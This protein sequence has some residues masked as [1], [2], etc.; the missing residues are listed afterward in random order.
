MGTGQPVVGSHAML[1]GPSWQR[2]ESHACCGGG[3]AG[4][5]GLGRQPGIR[6]LARRQSHPKQWEP[7]AGGCK[8]G[9]LGQPLCA[10]LVSLLTSPKLGT[11]APTAGL[12]VGTA[13]LLGQAFWN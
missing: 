1:V 11:Q 8:P 7:G 6:N 12:P 3:L 13:S 2:L 4:D 9:G 10:P 5:T